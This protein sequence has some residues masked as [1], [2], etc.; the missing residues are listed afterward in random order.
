M[1]L[2]FALLAIVGGA[3]AFKARFRTSL[4]YTTEY[5]PVQKPLVL[6]DWISIEVPSKIYTTT[7]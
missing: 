5:I 7:P 4:C 2:S 1:L 3:L 6:F